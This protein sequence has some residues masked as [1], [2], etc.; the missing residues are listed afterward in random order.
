MNSV[1]ALTL[2][3]AAYRTAGEDPEF[4][5]TAR[6]RWSRDLVSF[7]LNEE[8][9]PSAVGGG[10]SDVVLEAMQQWNAPE[11]S[12]LE[13]QPAGVSDNPAIAG[14]GVNTIAWVRDW[15]ERGFTSNAPSTT[16]VQYARETITDADGNEKQ[17]EWRISEADV[18]LDA[19]QAWSLTPLAYSSAGSEPST[20]ENPSTVTYDLLSVLTHELGHAA[21]LLHPCEVGGEG[22]APDCGNGSTYA[23][24]TMFP[25][26]DPDQATLEVDDE[27]GLCF[28][29]QQDTCEQLGCD[30]GF[31]CV[32]QR[33]EP[34]C[35]SN[36]CNA[37]STC[38]DDECVADCATSDCAN[39]T[40]RHDRDCPASLRCS[41]R[42]C[43]PGLGVLGDPCASP[44]ECA[45]QACSK[46]GV[47]LASCE[48]NDDC[49]ES[50]K[51][52]AGLDG[53]RVCSTALHALGD[54]C[55]ESNQCLGEQCVADVADAPVCT[56]R[57]GEGETEC[58]L[59]WTCDLVAGRAVC[60]PPDKSTDG[61]C[62]VPAAAVA[63]SRR[64]DTSWFRWP[65]LFACS[66]ILLALAA[67]RRCAARA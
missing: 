67:R 21:G 9:E 60:L 61:G 20:C 30:T 46:N 42:H 57:C 37:G 3:A 64:A 28:L 66:S 39:A 23:D 54:D 62:S 5:G 31:T 10:V 18:Y 56:R 63:T 45:S 36:V 65:L 8:N 33:C 17:G 29:Y 14:D 6:V 34:L 41:N 7:V 47:C 48:Q 51:C 50:H 59:D 4:K 13:F 58:P 22:G 49:E 25:L 26:Y 11:C 55:K 44:R 40:C 2:S 27:R 15:R 53:S 35:G 32:D 52:R 43:I 16:D 1:T 38:V 19:R 12:S 24:V